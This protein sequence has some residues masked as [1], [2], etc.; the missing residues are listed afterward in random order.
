MPVLQIPERQGESCVVRFSKVLKC[1][2]HLAATDALSGSS[3]P[4]SA[5][6]GAEVNE[7]EEY[8]VD[9]VKGL[10]RPKT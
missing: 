3:F 5:F 7:V 9:G 8:E 1:S 6:N 4:S 2:C 10:G